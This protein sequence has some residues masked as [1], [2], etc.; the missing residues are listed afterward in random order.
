MKVLHSEKLGTLKAK[1]HTMYDSYTTPKILGQ[2]SHKHYKLGK[3]ARNTP[4]K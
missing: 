3:E 1:R 2:P 4:Q